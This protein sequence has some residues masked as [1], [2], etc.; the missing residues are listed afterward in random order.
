MTVIVFAAFFAS[1]GLNAGTPL[2]IASTPV[3]A[4]E[5]AGEGLEQQQD[6]ERL[7]PGRQG[8]GL[9]RDRGRGPGDDPECA[10]RRRSRRARP[11][12]R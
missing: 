11:T 2:A 12:K 4:T 9:R 7:G 6:A 3:R 5:P 8:V 1:G 10:D